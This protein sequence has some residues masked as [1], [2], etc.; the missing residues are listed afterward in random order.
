MTP[1]KW[2]KN[3]F[4]LPLLANIKTPLKLNYKI[5]AYYYSYIFLLLKI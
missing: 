3:I 1:E 4:M 2:N 5:E